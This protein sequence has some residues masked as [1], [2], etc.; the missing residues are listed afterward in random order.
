[1]ITVSVNNEQKQ[2]NA[3]CSVSQ[4]LVQ[5]RYTGEKIAVAINGEFVPR[6]RYDEYVLKASDCIDIVAPIQGG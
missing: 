3:H 1:M 6:G 4:A 2:L 5:W